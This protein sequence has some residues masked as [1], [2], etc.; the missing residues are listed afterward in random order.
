M[1]SR[2]AKNLAGRGYE[3]V[4]CDASPRNLSEFLKSGLETTALTSPQELASTP[5]VEAVVTMLPSSSHVKAVYCG[6]DGLLSAPEGV[7]P[8]LLIDTSTI[9]PLTA[10]EVAAATRKAKLHHG[11]HIFSGC[12]M[13]SPTFVDAPVSG[14]VT[15]AAAATLTFMCGG[16]EAGVA[17]ATPFLHAMGKNVMRLGPPGSGQAAKLCNNLALAIQM[18]GVAE[19]AALGMRLGLDPALLSQVFN[20]SSARCWSS[21]AYNPVPGVMEGVPASRDYQGGLCQQAD[22]ERPGLGSGRCCGRRGRP[23][24]GL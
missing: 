10:R 23:A 4:V 6:A 21:E 22:G 8:S 20:S 15:G 13:S 17:A 7:V 11:S 5:G 24:D 14:G 16:D 9:D 1:G 19:A 12:S 18:A 2:M 3:L